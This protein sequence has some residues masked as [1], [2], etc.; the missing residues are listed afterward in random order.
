MKAAPGAVQIPVIPVV[1]VLGFSSVITQ[2]VMIRELLCVYQGSELVVGVILGNWLFLSGLGAWLGRTLHPRLPGPVGSSVGLTVLAGLL[3]IAFLPVASVIALRFLRNVLFLRGAVVGIT[4]TIWSSLGLLLPFCVLSGLLL[5][6][7]CWLGSDDGEAVSGMRR[8]YIADSLGSLAGGLMFTFVWVRLLDHIAILTGVASMVVVTV[9]WVAARNRFRIAVGVCCCAL[10][11]LAGVFFGCNLEERSIGWQF[12]GQRLLDRSNSP[13]GQILI[14]DSGGQM[15]VIENGVAI[16]STHNVEPAEETA[17]YVMCQRP[18]ARRVLLVSGIVSGVLAEVLK[19]PVTEVVCVELDVRIIELTRRFL[20]PSIGDSR[21][22]LVT[23]DARRFVR[24]TAEP[25]D[26]V[27]LDLPSPSTTMI[28]RY[29]TMEFYQEVRRRLNPGGVLGFSVGHYENVVSPELATLLSSAFRTVRQVFPEVVVLPGGRVFFLAS[30]QALHMDIAERLSRQGIPTRYVSTNYLKAVLTADRLGDIQRG[31]EQRAAINRDFNPVLYYY[32]LRTWLSQFT[33]RLG[34]SE[35]ALLV[36]VLV[37]VAG[38]SWRAASLAVF[39]SGYTASALEVV[40][41]LAYQ[42][43]SGAMYQGLGLILAVF[44]A[45]L[46][47][48]AYA[49][50]SGS[51]RCC[52]GAV[53]GKPVESPARKAPMALRALGWVTLALAGFSVIVPAVLRGLVQSNPIHSIGRIADV[54]IPV[55]AFVLA[56]LVGMEFP[57]ASRAMRGDVAATASRLYRADFLGAFLGAL[58]TSAWLIPRL[59]LSST[60][61][62]TAGLNAAIGLYLVWKKDKS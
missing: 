59:G 29:F 39:I 2:L 12:P 22:R 7:A 24:E 34:A 31:V 60:C 10:G 54:G 33:A 14:T 15:N 55:L 48:G 20:G 6:V 17:H 32:Q 35:I 56:I 8:V 49:V 42:I 9:A 57:L 21:V 5:T 38:I 16:A 19:Y 45:G 36:L 4:G 18:Q 1:F 61:W 52:W 43:S 51:E 3:L 50:T 62:L 28:N 40:L 26:V 44:M 41:L 58:F 30:D 53:G 23:A 13:Y 47:V 46:A 37:C 25:F 11:V 27:I